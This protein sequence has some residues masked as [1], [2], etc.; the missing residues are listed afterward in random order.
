DPSV[1]TISAAGLIAPLKDGSTEVLV[2]DGAVRL[3]VPVMVSGIAD[4]VPVSFHQDVI[5]I[6]SK[7][8]CN[9]GGCHGKA[10]GQNG[11]KLSVFG[12]DAAGDFDAI[13]KEGRGRRVFPAAPESSL[14]IAKA[15]GRVPHGGGIKI[16]RGSA[17]HRRLIRW[18]NEGLRLD[19]EAGDSVVEVLV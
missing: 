6:L 4:P 1:V 18:M 8:G 5:P 14:L 19:E 3:S 2:T 10:E 9:S 13:V 12:F 11:F 17:W 15:T 16:E 7:A